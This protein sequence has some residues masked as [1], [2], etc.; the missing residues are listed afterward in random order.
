MHTQRMF[1]LVTMSG[2]VA[3]A[4]GGAL[5]SGGVEYAYDNGQMATAVGPPGSFN[6]NPE[7]LWGNYFFAEEGG[8]V[9][10]TIS[11][12]FGVNFP[13]DREVTVA[14]FD[15]PDDDGDPRNATFLTSTTGLPK[16]LGGSV[17]TDFEIDPT[18]VSGGFFVAVYTFTEAGEDRPAAAGGEG[19]TEHSWLVYNPASQG[20]NLENLG[21]NAMALPIDELGGFF[22]G[23]WMVRAKGVAPSGEEVTFVETFDDESNVGSWTWGTGNEFINPINGNPGPYLRDNTLSTCCP[24]L[25]TWPGTSSIFT[26]D[27]RAKGVTSVG[28][29]LVTNNASS[30]VDGRPLSL[31]LVNDNG[32][33][34][35]YEGKWGAYFVGD[36]NIPK[37][38]VDVGGDLPQ[39]W[40]SYDFTVDSQSETLPD[41]WVLFR[42]DGEPI[43]FTWNDVITDVSELWFNYG[44]PSGIFLFLAWDVGADNVRITMVEPEPIVGDLNGDGVVNVADMLILLGQWGP[45]SGDCA[46]DLNNDGVV[47]VADLLILLSNWG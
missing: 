28:V 45:C 9:I 32:S 23:A 26:G 47:D 7:M 1:A 34:G 42:F 31:I 10:T 12:A 18:E 16:T 29:D 39:G 6:P 44:D 24:A 4:A 20:V 2:L 43:D 37:P 41:G 35:D 33:P 27:F 11:A 13:D 36:V 25:S 38:G 22:T 30:G 8:E 15:D 17:F 21:A 40:T 14:L 3:A 46:A 5:L 19:F